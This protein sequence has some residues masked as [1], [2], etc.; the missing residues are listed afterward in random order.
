VSPLACSWPSWCLLWQTLISGSVDSQDQTE[1]PT[2]EGKGEKD[3]LCRT[4]TVSSHGYRDLCT[5]GP[6][7]REC[8]SDLVSKDVYHE[9]GSQGLPGK[10]G[11]LSLCGPFSWCR[12]GKAAEDRAGTLTALRVLWVREKPVL[13]LLTF[14]AFLAASAPA[15]LSKITKPTG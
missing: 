11:D 12:V 4:E 1:Y 9:W 14:N 2:W 6:W 5:A 8:C 15:R 7:Q 3:L 13:C 10:D